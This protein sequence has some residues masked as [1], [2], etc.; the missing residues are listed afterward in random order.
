MGRRFQNGFEPRFFAWESLRG[1]QMKFHFIRAVLGVFVVC[2]IFKTPVRAQ[3]AGATITGTITDAT[4][5][6]IANAQVSAKNVAT[7][8]VST[9]KSNSDGL[10]TV[11]NLIP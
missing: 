6:I 9:T 10:Y 7:S 8:V 11:T 2:F 1:E 3:V 5:G 4:G